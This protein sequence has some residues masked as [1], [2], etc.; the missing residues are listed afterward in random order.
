MMSSHDKIWNTEEIQDEVICFSA[1]AS[2]AEIGGNLLYAPQQI[3]RLCSWD[4]QTQYEQDRD[5][6]V[7]GRRILRTG[8]SRIPFLTRETYCRPYA[9]QPEK[10]WLRLPSG[11]EYMEIFP[12]IY[13]WQCRV[14][15]RHKERW[16][17]FIPQQQTSRLPRSMGMLD[18]GAPLN[19]VFYGDSITVG[20]EASG[21]DE[22]AVNLA[23][24]EIHLLHNR[25]PW[26][27][28]W[29]QVVTGALSEAYPKALIRKFNRSAGAATTGWGAENAKKLVGPCAPDLVVLAFGM[30]SL[31]DTPERFLAEIQEI[32]VQIRLGNPQCEFLLVS[33]MTPSDEI[34]G[35]RNNQLARQEAALAS[36][37]TT[38]PGIALA[39]VHAVFREMALRGKTHIDLTGNCINHPN[40]FAVRVYAQTILAVLGI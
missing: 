8:N 15:Y 4:G 1:D 31:Q 13:R 3:L 7:S 26:Q 22:H 16:T 36:L 24:E 17:G 30:N 11:N 29:A 23:C 32:L 27:P 10:A 2:G 34:A 14:S 28:A 9:G 25:P 5:F 38:S 19:L 40:D 6:T 39:P 18:S 35:L 21:C 37:C 33:P 20:W 12:E